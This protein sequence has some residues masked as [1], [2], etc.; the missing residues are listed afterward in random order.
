MFRHKV[1]YCRTALSTVLIERVSYQHVFRKRIC[2]S[3]LVGRLPFRRSAVCSVPVSRNQAYAGSI[4]PESQPLMKLRQQRPCARESLRI[5]LLQR[6]AQGRQRRAGHGLPNRA[7]FG[8]TG[9]SR[10]SGRNIFSQEISLKAN[11]YGSSA[12]Q[13]YCQANAKTR[14]WV[15]ARVT[16]TVSVDPYFD[17]KQ[18]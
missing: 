9:G 2:D 12:F 11:L 17:F 8:D 6:E 5:L 4:E 7:L 10:L 1:F 13:S 14:S 15:Y 3:H 18:R 16:E